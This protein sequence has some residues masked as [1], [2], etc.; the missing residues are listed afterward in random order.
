MSSRLDSRHQIWTLAADLGLPR[1]ESPSRRIREFVIK[2]VKLVA[3]K[4]SCSSLG[5]LLDAVA[6]DVN[7]VFKEIHSDHDLQEIQREFV[8]RGEPAFARLEME[9]R[10]PEDFAITIKLTHRQPWDPLFVSVIDCRGNKRNRCYFSKWHELA[11]LL[12]LTRQMR[13]EFRRTH[14]DTA[15]QDPEE[16]LMDTIAADAG[17][18]PELVGSSAGPEIS[19]DGIRQIKQECCPEASAQ[20]AT[21]GI[22][23]ALPVPCILVEAKLA[24]RKHET[25]NSRQLGLGIAEAITRPALRAI[26][27]TVNEAASAA[28]IRFHK[29]WRVPIRS[30]MTRVFTQSGHAKAAE[31]LS[32][33]ETSNGSRLEPC[34]VIVEARKGWDSVHALLIP[35]V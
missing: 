24:Y 35:Q 13:L 3:A 27:V 29:Q 20:A 25:E 17:F 32:W 16:A 1:S 14:S 4:F 23:K 12:T 26:N 22:V 34:P 11:H 30:V 19:F 7:T 6:A 15:R 2:R 31:D 21:I 18:L 8:S 10:G 9:L 33:W 5:A 28:G